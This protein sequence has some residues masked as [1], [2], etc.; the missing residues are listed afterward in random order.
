MA[1]NKA[2]TTKKEVN[3]EVY[4]L[5]AI[6]IIKS[7]DSKRFGNLADDLMH[8]AN[9]VHDLYPISSAG[10]FELMVRRSGRYQ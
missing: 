2:N 7:G 6:H 8:Q 10:A 1:E 9:L 3:D 4:K 5:A